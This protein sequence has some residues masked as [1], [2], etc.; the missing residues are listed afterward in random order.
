MD[1]INRNNQFSDW[2]FNEFVKHDRKQ[3]EE[4]WIFSRVLKT[5]AKI[6]LMEKG[7]EEQR[8]YAEKLIGIIA[9]AVPEFNTHLLILRGAEKEQDYAERM[10]RYEKRLRAIGYDEESIKEFINKKIKLN[11]GN[12]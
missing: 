10:E 12:D 5:Y 3:K 4:A 9:E 1:S 8:K 11:Y 7:Q 6:G 2:L